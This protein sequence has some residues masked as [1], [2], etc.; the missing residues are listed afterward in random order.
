MA[1]K[2]SE[3][4]LQAR[5]KRSQQSEDWPSSVLANNRLTYEHIEI[6]PKSI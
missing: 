6:I 5:F 1:D 3:C 2:T 4:F